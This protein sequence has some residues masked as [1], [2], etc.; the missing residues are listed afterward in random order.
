[1]TEAEIVL[2]LRAAGC[3][4]A[5]D[6]AALLVAEHRLDLDAMVERRVAG[7]PLEYLLGWAEFHG[8]RVALDPGV[9][10][11]RHRTELLV[12]EALRLCS[13][14]SVVVDLCCGAGG[15][16]AVM[17]H[18]M[19]TLD[20]Y[21]AD[22]DPSAVSSARRN[23]P[24]ERVFEGDLFDALPISLR[25]RIE[26]LAVNTPYVPT[27][28]IAFM[29]TEARDHEHRVALDGGADGLEL[30]RRVAGL[31]GGWL[32]PGGS[33]LVETGE[34]QAPVSVALFEAA[35]LSAR[36]VDDDDATVVIATSSTR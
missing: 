24:P 22:V 2:R 33:L 4:F 1:M 6:E 9:F 32:A 11:P 30:Q 17:L 3:V 27:E 7:E 25:G 20:L 18:R 35:G 8:I 28:E 10:V 36:I 34:R 19:P 12:D 26:V 29:P 21:A 31:A 13:P 16:G 5:E 23:L 14:G 15:I